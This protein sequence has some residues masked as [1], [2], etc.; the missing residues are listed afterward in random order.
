[1]SRWTLS[2]LQYK[3]GHSAAAFGRSRVIDVVCNPPVSSDNTYLQKK[4][5]FLL[6]WVKFLIQLL[7]FLS[8]PQNGRPRKLQGLQMI[9]AHPHSSSS[10]HH[11]YHGNHGPRPP[12]RRRTRGRR[13]R[14]PPD[15]VS[16]RGHLD[17]N[18]TDIELRRC[19]IFNVFLYTLVSI[20]SSLFCRYANHTLCKT[21]K[22]PQD[23]VFCRRWKTN[24]S[25]AVLKIGQAIYFWT[26]FPQICWSFTS[27]SN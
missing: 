24:W 4:R 11:G 8:R 23:D 15:V 12:R 5:N 19:W 10:R 6:A 2:N 17:R 21:I 9:T 7:P 27:R 13:E 16:L 18:T 20:Q 3:H 14:S 22:L 26:I 25:N 1:M